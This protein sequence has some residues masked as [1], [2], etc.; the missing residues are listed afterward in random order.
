MVEIVMLSAIYAECN[1]CRV[2][3]IKQFMLSAVMLNVV[4]LS[5][6]APSW[7]REKENG[8]KDFKTSFSFTL[9]RL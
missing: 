5:G 2:T 6:V 8:D 9:L 4:M 1:L 7:H 3:H